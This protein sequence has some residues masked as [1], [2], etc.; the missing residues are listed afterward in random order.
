MIDKDL[1]V[2]SSSAAMTPVHGVKID[3]RYGSN[4]EKS[5]NSMTPVVGVH[6]STLSVQ[7]GTSSANP[8]TQFVDTERFREFLRTKH[9]RQLA[10]LGDSEPSVACWVK[11]CRKIAFSKVSSDAG[12]VN[13]NRTSSAASILPPSLD[14][15]VNLMGH[16]PTETNGLLSSELGLLIYG[17][18][19]DEAKRVVATIN[20]ELKDMEKDR[21][22]KAK[23]RSDREDREAREAIEKEESDRKAK[24]GA[25]EAAATGAEADENRRTRGAAKEQ[26]AVIDAASAAAAAAESGYVSDPETREAREKEEKDKESDKQKQEEAEDQWVQCDACEKW[27]RLPKREHENYPDELSD[28]WTCEMNTWNSEYASCSAPQEEDI[29]KK[30]MSKVQTKAKIW[31]RKILSNDRFMKR[32]MGNLTMTGSEET[33]NNPHGVADWIRCTNPKCGK[34]R[35]CLRNMSAKLIRDEPELD[36]LDECLG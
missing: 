12:G 4:D 10:L 5:V 32:Y 24:E 6:N 33:I 14:E 30:E 1:R 35:S 28:S 8:K 13:G 9:K 3:E 26:Q 31:L 29:V 7:P 19:S 15:A 16:T 36:V 27:R 25:E 22:A 17:S 20:A 18:Q 21:K 11:R 2:M 34:W 23:A